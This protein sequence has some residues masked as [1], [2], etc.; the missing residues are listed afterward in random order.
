MCVEV[1]MTR[2]RQEQP[3]ISPQDPKKK[4]NKQTRSKHGARQVQ[5]ENRR[6][7]QEEKRR[8]AGSGRKEKRL[9]RLATLQMNPALYFVF[10]R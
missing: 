2:K 6:Q 5:E 1:R 8:A 9:E 10:T 7:V 4:K 3:L